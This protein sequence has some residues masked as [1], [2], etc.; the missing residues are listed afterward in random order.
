M[1][2]SLV[3]KS[4]NEVTEA[5]IRDKHLILFGDPGSNSLLAKA[6][7]MLPL[8]WSQAEVTLG[9]KP[10]SAQ[11]HAPVFICRNPLAP[12]RYLV[13]NSGHT[14][15]EKDFAAFNYLLFPRL[16]DWALL[17]ISRGS[18]QWSPASSGFPEEV[19]SAGYFD[20][21]WNNAYTVQP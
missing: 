3:I 17:R 21:T 9:G 8:K 10:Q 12:N 7:P 15:H 5:D 4:D 6:L 14:F 16:G 13:V 11:Q 1:R 2:G 19:L 20:E 18:D